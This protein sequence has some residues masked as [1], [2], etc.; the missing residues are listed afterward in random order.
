LPL[1]SASARLGIKAYNGNWQTAAG[2]AALADVNDDF[3]DV[4]INQEQADA[5]FN[6]MADQKENPIPYTGMGDVPN[7]FC[8]LALSQAH[9]GARGA[10]CRVS[11]GASGLC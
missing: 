4:P 1:E 5:L 3:Q 9:K 10:S 7:G 8:I 2:A 6:V 11:N